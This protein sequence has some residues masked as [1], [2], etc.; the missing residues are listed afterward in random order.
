MLPLILIRTFKLETTAKC[1]DHILVLI[2]QWVHEVCDVCLLALNKFTQPGGRK[3]Q[4]C[5]DSEFHMIL[6]HMRTLHPVIRKLISSFGQE[7]LWQCDGVIE[8]FRDHHI[9]TVPRAN[10]AQILPIRI[11]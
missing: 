7:G 9:N 10:Q 2:S 6:A 3:F 5:N 1:N 8:D 4:R 11:Q